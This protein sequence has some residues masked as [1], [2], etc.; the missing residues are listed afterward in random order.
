MK[1]VLLRGLVRE[2]RHWLDFPA[3]FA[4]NVKSPDGT[5]TEPVLLDLPGFGTE[6]DA[7]VPASIDGFVD[8]VRARLRRV[9]PEHEKVAL[10]AVSLG[11]MVALTW[12]A[13]HPEDFVGAVVVNSSIGDLS[14]PWQRMQPHNWPHI[15]RAAFLDARARERL[16][17]SLTRHQG[18]LDKDADRYAAIAT[19]IVPKKKNFVAQL[20]AALAVKAPARIDVPTLVLTSKGDALVSW[21]CSEAISKRLSL[22]LVV[23]QGTGAEAAGHDLPLDAPGWVCDQVNAWAVTLPS[24]S[25][26]T[27]ATSPAAA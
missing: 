10:L 11:G 5:P 18:D 27:P 6:N 16:L 19:S 13:K 23:H 17:L 22:P 1:W 9:V 21:K 26:K 15:A 20:R 2:Q 12:L 4:A 3:Y 24:T 7:V 25:T 14:P 8:D